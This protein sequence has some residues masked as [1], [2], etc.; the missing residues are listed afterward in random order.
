MFFTNFPAEAEAGIAVLRPH[1][2]FAETHQSWLHSSLFRTI[3]QLARVRGPPDIARVALLAGPCP[4]LQGTL[5]AVR[6]SLTSQVIIE[7]GR[8]SRALHHT[9]PRIPS[10]CERFFLPR[11]SSKVTIIG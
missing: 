2:L 8:F 4:G 3:A 10:G 7:N 11:Q 5:A 6:A 9:P 1:F